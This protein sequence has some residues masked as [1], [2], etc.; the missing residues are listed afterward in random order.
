MVYLWSEKIFVKTAY[1]ERLQVTT[2]SK[3]QNRL[4]QCFAKKVNL[5]WLNQL[6]YKTSLPDA[7][8]T[9]V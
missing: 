3:K 6:D 5:N 9:E 8:S 1:F 2:I 7:T 4:T